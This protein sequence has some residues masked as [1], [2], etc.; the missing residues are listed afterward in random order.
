MSL[1]TTLLLVNAGRTENA[2]QIKTTTTTN[3]HYNN[4]NNDDNKL[5]T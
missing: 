1:I 4:N 2:S 3:Q 5:E